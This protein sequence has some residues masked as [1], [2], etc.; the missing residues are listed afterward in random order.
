MSTDL[1]KCVLYSSKAA[2]CSSIVLCFSEAHVKV[3]TVKVM[4]SAG[5]LA[6]GTD[7]CL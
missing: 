7:D 1:N 3:Q 6:G 4:F 2:N 5:S